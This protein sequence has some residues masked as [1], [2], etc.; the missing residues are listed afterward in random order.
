MCRADPALAS[1]EEESSPPGVPDVQSVGMGGLIVS[2]PEELRN[3][4]GCG[5][6]ARGVGRNE[7]ENQ[8]WVGRDHTKHHRL[9]LGG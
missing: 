8:R 1:R 6:A 5:T 7:A 9:L 2:G 3:W 4:H